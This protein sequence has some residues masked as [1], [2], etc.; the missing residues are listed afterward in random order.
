VLNWNDT[1]GRTRQHVVAKLDE[2]I[3]FA[4]NAAASG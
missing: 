1:Q 2:V 3:D 4:L